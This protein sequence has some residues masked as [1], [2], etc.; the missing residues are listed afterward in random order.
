MAKLRDA[1]GLLL[2][3]VATTIAELNL[4]DIDT[5]AVELAKHYAAAIDAGHCSE[6]DADR[7]LDLLGPKLLA[8]LESLGATPAA[9]SKLVKGGP[10]SRAANRLAAIR[11]AR[12]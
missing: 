1:D 5:A 12:G 9:R 6:C 3:A 4:D 10:P 2:T 7:D 8:V 11:E